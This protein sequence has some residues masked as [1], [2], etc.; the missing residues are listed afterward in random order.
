[1]PAADKSLIGPILTYVDH[2]TVHLAQTMHIVA[3][4]LTFQVTHLPPRPGA[5]QTIPGSVNANGMGEAKQF[6]LQVWCMM[7]CL[8]PMTSIKVTML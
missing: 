7:T 5:F 6:L 1:M 3:R 2:V 8:F 4:H